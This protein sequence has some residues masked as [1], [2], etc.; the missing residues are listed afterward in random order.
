[1]FKIYNGVDTVNL[2]KKDIHKVEE[3]CLGFG[4]S[5]E[6]IEAVISKLGFQQWPKNSEDNLRMLYQSWCKN[7]PQDNIHKRI[8]FGNQ[9]SGPLPI[10]NP[11]EFFSNFLEHSTGGTCWGHSIGLYSLIKILGYDVRAA[12]GS[13]VGLTPPENGPSHGTVIVT[14]ED[15]QYLVYGILMIEDIVPLSQERPSIGGPLPFTIKI[16]PNFNDLWDIVFRTGHSEKEL[17]CRLEIDNVEF[18]YLQ[19]RWENTRNY[20]PF[21]NSL[22]IRKNIGKK[23]VTL[24]RNKLFHLNEDGNITVE[25]IV[26]NLEKKR[27]LINIFDLSEEIVN[28]IP[29]DDP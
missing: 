1:M 24:S 5:F 16:Y 2:L 12:A 8:Y 28:A 26:T 3:I 6:L 11:S 23:A 27:I 21:N 29:L 18:S 10:G 19:E 15:Q 17:T 20:S 14:I 4:V 22:F 13:M 9:M 25:E 7:V